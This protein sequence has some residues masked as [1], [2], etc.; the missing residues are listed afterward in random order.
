MTF[1]ATATYVGDVSVYGFAYASELNNFET[2]FASNVA[3]IVTAS[4]YGGLWDISLTS[5]LTDNGYDTPSQPSMVSGLAN[6][7]V[8]EVAKSTNP[9]DIRYMDA[10]GTPSASALTFA[11]GSTVLA[12][13]TRG[14]VNSLG[15]A[16]RAELEGMMDDVDSS[17]STL[18]SAIPSKVSELQNDSGYITASAIPSN[19]SAFNNDAGY[20]TASAIP[21]R[22]SQLQNDAAYTNPTAVKALIGEKERKWNVS[23]LP[24]GYEWR[25][26]VSESYSDATHMWYYDISIY[27]VTLD[28]YAT[29]SNSPYSSSTQV[30]TFTITDFRVWPEGSESPL[31]TFDATATFV[32]ESSAYG[33]AYEVKEVQTFVD[34]QVPQTI[35]GWI[36]TSALQLSSEMREQDPQHRVWWVWY[37]YD[38]LVGI[39]DKMWVCYDPVADANG[40]APALIGWDTGYGV[41]DE[42]HMF[43]WEYDDGELEQLTM[44]GDNPDVQPSRI[45]MPPIGYDHWHDYFASQAAN[46]KIYGA[47]VEGGGSYHTSYIYGYETLHVLPSTTSYDVIYEDALEGYAPLQKQMTY[48]GDVL[49]PNQIDGGWVSSTPAMG[50]LNLNSSYMSQDTQKRVWWS[51]QV[52]YEPEPSTILYIYVVACYDATNDTFKANVWRDQQEGLPQNLSDLGDT[53]EWGSFSRASGWASWRDFFYNAPDDEYEVSYGQYTDIELFDHAFVT[54]RW[55]G[56]FD[57]VY[58]GELVNAYATRQYVDEQIGNVLTEEF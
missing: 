3:N 10:T 5:T 9:S 52:Q 27:N 57:V 18:A 33:F 6:V 32:K 44:C 22:V 11:D 24:A 55:G 43:P 25:T 17:I 21:T 50:R 34:V 19:V 58:E 39:H 2:N 8:M 46:R 38:E 53:D 1:D 30:T 13:A 45:G 23:G 29:S 49:V 36:G 48:E 41:P 47:Y 37:Y 26:S 40:V 51:A 4:E 14:M 20:V 16:T 56:L 54:A 7:W 12:S 28:E 42:G 31:M 35:Q 15:L